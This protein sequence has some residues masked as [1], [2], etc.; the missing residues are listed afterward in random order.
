MVE[1]RESSGTRP[2]FWFAAI[3]GLLLLFNMV[4]MPLAWGGV[5]A[6]RGLLGTI[7]MLILLGFLLILLFDLVSLVWAVRLGKARGAAGPA[8]GLII[9][10]CLAL[11]GMMGAKVMVDEIARET[12]LGRG[13]G[14]WAML[15]ALLTI[16]LTYIIVVF[17]RARPAPG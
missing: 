2:M 9:L 16:Q 17:S 5:N 3:A 7:Q 8:G 12:P 11:I 4:A 10:G 14:E 6:E 15:Y 1:Q 13:G